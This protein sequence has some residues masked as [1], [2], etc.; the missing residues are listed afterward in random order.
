MQ[1]SFPIGR[2]WAARASVLA[3]LMAAVVVFLPPSA[4]AT[5]AAY[6]PGKVVV[7]FRS[8]SSAALEAAI[9]ARS[10]A[11]LESAP[12]PGGALLDVRRGETVRAAIARLRA[13]DL[14]RSP[15]ASPHPV[16]EPVALRGCSAYEI[17]QWWARRPR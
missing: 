5:G 1:I 13:H 8:A 3:A 15:N 4:S 7:G 10:G 11:E 17:E 12:E 16:T 2:R 9:A 6:V 14:H